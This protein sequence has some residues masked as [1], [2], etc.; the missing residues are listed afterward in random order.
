MVGSNPK[1]DFPLHQAGAASLLIYLMLAWCSHNTQLMTLSL[2]FLTMLGAGCLLGVTFYRYR[3]RNLSPSLF[4]IMLWATAFRI[5]GIYGL[6]I[7]EDDFYRYLWDGFQ[8]WSTGDPYSLAPSAFFT[9]NSVPTTFQKLL[10][11]I[12]YPDIPTIYAPTLQYSFLL[13]HWITPGDVLGLK[14]IYV[15]T[16]LL[17]IYVLDKISPYRLL[18]LLYAWNPLVIKEIAFTAHPDGFGVFFLVIAYFFSQRSQP[19]VL[20]NTV[21]K[22]TALNNTLTMVFLAIGICAK[23]FAWFIA[24]FIIFRLPLRYIPILIGTVVLLYLPFVLHSREVLTGLL[25]F[26]RD[27]QFNAAI[28]SLLALFAPVKIAKLLSVGLFIGVYLIYFL[29][30][31]RQRDKTIRFDWIL[32]GLLFCSPV[33]NPWYWLWVLPFGVLFPSRWIWISSFALLLSYVCGINTG[34]PNLAPY[35]L[36]WWVAGVE[37]GIIALAIFWDSMTKKPMLPEEP[38]R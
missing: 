18:V 9:D 17:L 3:Q 7:F 22:N 24:P 26:G 8:F 27:W 19:V 21:L 28:F 36:E 32:A 5:I 13:G 12:N 20:K 14:L 34:N 38:L 4:S 37:Y 31:V 11:G 25:A 16:D 10:D 1:H 29:Q 15:L 2:F 6:P 33:I 30:F 35:Q 23:P